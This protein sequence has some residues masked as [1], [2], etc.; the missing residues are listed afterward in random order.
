LLLERLKT[1]S[2]KLLNEMHLRH[3]AQ[4]LDTG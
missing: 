2:T 1:S 3:L 4:Y